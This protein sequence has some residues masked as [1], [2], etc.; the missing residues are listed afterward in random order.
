MFVLACKESGCVKLIC[1]QN[2]HEA[3]VLPT[4]V[5][6]HFELY[7]FIDNSDYTGKFLKVINNQLVD[8]GYFIELEAQKST[9]L[10]DCDECP[11]LYE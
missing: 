7:E 5:Y 3:L 2:P 10:L 8:M 4:N 11:P 1:S 6:E 9:T